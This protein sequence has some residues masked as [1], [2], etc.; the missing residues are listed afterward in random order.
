MSG[1][2][3]TSCPRKSTTSRATWMVITVM[4][5]SEAVMAK[6]ITE[7]M[8]MIMVSVPWDAEGGFCRNDIEFVLWVI[9]KGSWPSIIFDLGI[10]GSVVLKI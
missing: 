10:V 7:V 1:L 8:V 5:I 2:R 3:S 9:T 6:A 4:A